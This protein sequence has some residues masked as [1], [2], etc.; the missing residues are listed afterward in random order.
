MRVWLCR[1]WTVAITLSWNVLQSGNTSLGRGCLSLWQAQIL[2]GWGTEIEDMQGR[3]VAIL[4][5]VLTLEFT[6]IG[7]FTHT[8]CFLLVKAKLKTHSCQAKGKSSSWNASEVCNRKSVIAAYAFFSLE[9]PLQTIS[10]FVE[11]YSLI[12]STVHVTVP[13][14]CLPLPPRGVKLRLWNV[15]LKS[16]ILPQGRAHHHKHHIFIGE[17]WN[18][19]K[20]LCFKKCFQR[21]LY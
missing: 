10:R 7:G 19:Y 20:K 4:E 3:T 17:I 6:Q 15:Y 18:V 13:S 14:H 5:C 12:G 8:Q 2:T 16:R 1:E 21:K 9:S 11:G